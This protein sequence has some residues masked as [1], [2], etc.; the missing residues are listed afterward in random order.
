MMLPYIN[1]NTMTYVGLGL[2][3]SKL[4]LSKS[5]SLFDDLQTHISEGNV[6]HQ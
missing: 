4:F 3:T 5:S 1:V 6:A 2:P